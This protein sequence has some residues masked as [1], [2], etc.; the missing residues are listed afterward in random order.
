MPTTFPSVVTN[1]GHSRGLMYVMTRILSAPRTA[2]HAAWCRQAVSRCS[3]VPTCA[4]PSMAHAAH[5]AKRTNRFNSGHK[6]CSAYN[7][8]SYK[9]R[10][11]IVFMRTCGLTMHAE[12][13]CTIAGH[14][15]CYCFYLPL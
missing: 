8:S 14:R 13:A 10:I 9:K 1:A 7:K 12:N 4:P 5:V 3:G 6:A 15:R 11:V 2:P